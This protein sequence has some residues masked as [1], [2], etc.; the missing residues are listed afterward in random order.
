MGRI[1]GADDFMGARE[2]EK[3]AAVVERKRAAGLWQRFEAAGGIR[4]WKEA[5]ADP[6]LRSWAFCE[7][8]C[9]ESA[10]VA[11]DDPRRAGSLAELALELASTLPGELRGEKDRRA[12]TLE[13]VWVHLGNV[14]RILGDLEGAEEAFKKAQRCFIDAVGLLPSVLD[15][16][17][18]EALQALLRRD[19]G[20]FREAL[21]KLDFGLR[22]LDAKAPDRPAFLLEKGRLH[23]RLGNPER[24]VQPLAEAAETVAAGA[25]PRLLLRIRLEL[26]SALCEMGRYEEARSLPALPPAAG[27]EG[28]VGGEGMRLICLEGRIAAG[29]GRLE[30]AEAALRKAYRAFQEGPAQ[31]GTSG[32]DLALLSLE[33]AALCAREERRTGMREVTGMIQELSASPALGREAAATL[34]LFCRLAG[35]DKL[36]AERAA[37]FAEDFSKS[38]SRG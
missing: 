35:Q 34:K 12:Q 28:E 17:R 25:D 14:R 7:R 4:A 24:A 22:F 26:G 13:Y 27:G 29:A 37:R 9:H 6:E 15:R 21:E 33:I 8:L 5:L 1:G 3:A 20:Q 10:A 32:A 36:S 18:T 38:S 2:K 30:E 19:R 23:R 11:E 31:D 16:G